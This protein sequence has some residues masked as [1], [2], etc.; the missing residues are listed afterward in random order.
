MR[1]SRRR[2]T[3]LHRAEGQ[4]ARNEYYVTGF[5]SH[6]NL[7]SAGL[8]GGQVMIIHKNNDPQSVFDMH[9]AL[10]CPH[11]A[12]HSNIS[13]I[14]IPR[15]EFLVRFQ[16]AIVGIAYRCD[17]CNMPVFL[18]FKVE[19]YDTGNNRIFLLEE[20]EEIERPTEV[21]EFQ[22]LPSE[23]S[24]AFREALTCYSASCLNAFASMCRRT[25]QS[26]F[27][28]L[29]AEGKDRVLNQLKDVKDT[30]ELDD[31]TYSILEQIIIAGHDGAHPYLPSLSKERAAVLLELMKDVLYQLFVRRAKIQEAVTM[32]REAIEKAK[33]GKTKA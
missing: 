12:V 20:Y 21:F 30:A 5:N 10:T 22:Y 27:A 33:E 17:S 7:D 31:E 6:Q 23:V 13:A 26:S 1:L 29:G 15:Y 2:V 4:N 16:P 32:R 28:E 14:S 19:K 9:F 3:G 18:R 24:N 8:G 11:C 25:L